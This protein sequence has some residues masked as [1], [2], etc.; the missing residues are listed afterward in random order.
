MNIS[1]TTESE[2]VDLTKAMQQSEIT[3]LMIYESALTKMTPLRDQEFG[4]SLHNV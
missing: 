1:P 4:C 2:L 3:L